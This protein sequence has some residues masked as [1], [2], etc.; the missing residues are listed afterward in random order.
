[1]AQEE[2]Y[3]KEVY[4]FRVLIYCIFNKPYTFEV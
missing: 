1:M 4:D 3:K 2:R